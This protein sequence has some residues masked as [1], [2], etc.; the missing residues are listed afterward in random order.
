MQ[1]NIR[2]TWFFQQPPAEVWE[3]LTRPELIEQWL[4]KT[5]FKPIAGYKFR[6]TFEPKNDSK[7]EGIVDC[8]VLEVDPF[9]KL[10]YSW[11][12]NTQDRTRS[13]KSKVVWTLMPKGSGTELQLQHDGF[14]FPDDILTHSSGWNVCLKRFEERLNTLTNERTNA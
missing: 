8:E 6:F 9:T 7:Y 5:D 11:N 13:F 1:N 2:Q 10:S 3:Y 14:T 4:M 12:G